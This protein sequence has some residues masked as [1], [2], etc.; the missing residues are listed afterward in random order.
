MA[1]ST[2]GR[3]V[4]NQRPA[5]PFNAKALSELFSYDGPP[6]RFL[7]ELLS[8]QCHLAKCDAGVVLRLGEANRIEALAAYPTPNNNGNSLKWI[9]KAEKPFRRVMK[10]GQTVIVKENSASE[11]SDKYQNYLVVIPIQNDGAL[12]AAA[13]FRIKA[14]SHYQLLLSHARLETTALLL[15]H[16]EMR[17]TTKMHHEAMNRLRRVLE[18]LDTVNKS[19]RFLSAAMALCNE[20]STRLG[21]SRV[22]LGLLDGRSV[23]VRAMSH[24]DSFGR[25]MDVVQAIEA[26]MEECLDQDVEV[27][28]P[29]DDAAMYADRGSAKLSACHGPSSI[30]SLPIREDGNVT[31]VMT[32]ERSPEQPFNRLAEI[33]TLRLIGDLCAPRLLELSRSDRW[34]GARMASRARQQVGVL[35][36]HEHTWVKLGAVLVFLMAVFFTTAKGDYRIK[37]SF[38]LQAKNQQVVVAP[39]DT[40]TKS[41]SVEPGDRVE[42]GK[43]ILGTLETSELR[44][45]LA[46]LKAEQLGYQK[47]MAA[48]MRDRKTAEAQ[49]AQAQSD[50]VA[51]EIRLI[52]K[53]IEQATLVSPITGWVV[54]EDLKQQI[55]AP[56]ETGKVL[57]EI[58]AIDSLRAEL[59]VPES[60]IANVATGQEG[61]LA[62]VGHPDQ[63][64]RFVIERINPI[65]EV[66]NNQN[67]FRV[68]ARILENLEWMR[69]GMEGEARISAGKKSYLWI[70]SHRLVN[71]LRMKLWV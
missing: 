43:A 2:A 38:A 61:E 27:I 54:S 15:D 35:L 71:W 34:F 1:G 8:T 47:Q 41:V 6:D 55:G 4:D 10:S 5:G 64:I 70:A 39:F 65:A 12:R 60:S 59:Y 22:S 49:I 30:L 36:G 44:L 37:T 45:K 66:V 57:F 69:P 62:S 14:S 32:L 58:A 23:R 46:A 11:G 16:H 13:A 24:T 3:S 48:S 40:F 9:S 52:E 17:L 50:K 28:H 26:T 68:R 42:G 67:V 18:V 56:V 7:S 51:A 20:I 21:C 31:A 19:K 63:K 25:E 33:E 53:K 29:K